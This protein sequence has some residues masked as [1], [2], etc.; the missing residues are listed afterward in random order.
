MFIV[1]KLK[2]K[3]IELTNKFKLF[4]YTRVK[5]IIIIIII[6]IIDHSPLG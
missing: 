6:I 3:K 4:I 1:Y 2:Q 5:Q